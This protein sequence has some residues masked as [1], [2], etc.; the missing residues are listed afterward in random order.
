MK[1]FFGLL[2]LTCSLSSFAQSLNMN[3][4]SSKGDLISVTSLGE[5]SALEVKVNNKRVGMAHYD[6]FSQGKIFVGKDGYSVFEWQTY[7]E[8]SAKGKWSLNRY[9][10]CNSYY[11]EEKCATDE[12][13]L[14]DSSALKCNL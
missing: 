4:A 8:R 2:I 9:W 3:C 7:L 6:D 10:Y 12:L 13:V 11:F 14:E 5:H 1:T